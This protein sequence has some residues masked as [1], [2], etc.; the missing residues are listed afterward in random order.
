[1]RMIR[2]IGIQEA[3]DALGLRRT[4]DGAAKLLEY[5][6]LGMPY[7]A[8]GSTYELDQIV[9]WHSKHIAREMAR[10]EEENRKLKEEK[11]EE[12]ECK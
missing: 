3:L 6:K 7:R 9:A 10:L 5:E 8:T 11:E 1:M 2:T 12:E 4:P